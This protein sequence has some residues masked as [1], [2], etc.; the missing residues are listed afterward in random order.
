MTA[1]VYLTLAQV[2]PALMIAVVLEMRSLRQAADEFAAS[3][4]EWIPSHPT[5]HNPNGWLLKALNLRK[6]ITHLYGVLPSSAPHYALGW[7]VANAF[8]AIGA[9]FVVT[10]GLC[11]FAVVVEPHGWLNRFAE[12]LVLAGLTILGLCL[13]AM[14]YVTNALR[15]ETMAMRAELQA[16]E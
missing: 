7:R 13:V 12:I 5:L 10:E 16:G 3:L 8:A 15:T 9:A 2:L 6:D 14:P 1:A 4:V 11:L